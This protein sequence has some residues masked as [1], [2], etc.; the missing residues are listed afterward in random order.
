[1]VR[2]KIRYCCNGGNIIC[3]PF[4]GVPMWCFVSAIYGAETSNTTVHFIHVQ[5]SKRKAVGMQIDFIKAVIDVC[6]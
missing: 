6:F 5:G 3:C 2:S 1:M 4:L